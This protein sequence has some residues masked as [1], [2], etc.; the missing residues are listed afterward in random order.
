MQIGKVIRKYRKNKNMTQEEMAHRL[1]VT[2][3]AVNKWENGVSMPDIALLAPIARLLNITIDTLLSF[4]DE[5]TKEEIRA[6]VR[7]L[8]QR[9]KTG[10]YA[11]AFQWA[12]E[13]L[14]KYPNCEYLMWQIAVIL[15]AHRVMQNLSDS[16]R[17]DEYILECYH[18]I[19]DSQDEKIRT[20]AADSLFGYYMRVEDYEKAEK[21][22]EYFSQ[23]NP[24]RKRKQAQLY[25]KKGQREDAYRSYE[26]MLFSSYQMTSMLFHSIYMMA[27]EDGD[28]EKAHSMT[29]KQQGL[30]RLFEM[31]KYYEA[32]CQLEL[33][34]LEEDGD[35]VREIMQ[36]MLENVE[37]L[38]DFR[39][40]SLY[41]HMKFQEV[42]ADFK[43]T[44]KQNLTKCF[45]DEESFGFLKTEKE[46]ERK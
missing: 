14:E 44:M 42:S 16:E 6:L 5:L 22:L 15:D 21:Y 19:L 38:G 40:N 43:K 24:E 23:Q 7:Q 46:I 37:E 30:A 25:E 27:L 39:K 29:E 26:E 36:I 34:A 9:L 17:Y 3:P 45:Q 13:I 31:G 35:T 20:H 10:D 12:Q 33:A 2:A 11:D 18:Q 28:M 32:S 4:Q 8:D 41:R 1:G